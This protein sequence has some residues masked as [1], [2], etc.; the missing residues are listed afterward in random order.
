[1]SQQ[2]SLWQAQQQAPQ[3]AELC[4]ALYE[5]ELTSLAANTTL[6]IQALQGRMKSLPHYIKRA[7]LLMTSVDF[8]LTIDSQNATWA[9]KQPS[10]LPLSQQDDDATWSWYFA[11]PLPYGLVVP[12]ALADRIVLDCIDRVDTENKRL[13]TNV[14]GWFYSPND[15]KNSQPEV[16][17]LKPNK[18]VMLAA[19]AGHCW[20]NQLKQRPIIPSL[21]EL[22]LSC[23]IN[24]QDFTKPQQH[25]FLK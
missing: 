5:R 12:I 23:D 22:L 6:S 19:C 24:W 1:M 20:K 11:K 3:F 9:H 2:T 21:R 8:P 7:A 18:K 10:K 25:D 14:F 13:R 4:N 17:L 16:K 15:L